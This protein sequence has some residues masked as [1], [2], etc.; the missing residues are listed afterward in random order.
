M[1]IP[2]LLAPDEAETLSPI[3][4]PR[5]SRT[6]SRTPPKRRNKWEDGCGESQNL[7]SDNSAATPS[8]NS[9]APAHSPMTCP[10]IPTMMPG[11]LPSMQPMPSHGVPLNMQHVN[12]N[13]ML[14]LGPDGYRRRIYIGS[15]DYSI[16]ES[17][18][19][20]LFSSFGRVTNVEMPREGTPPR[21]KGFCFLEYSDPESAEKALQNMNEYPLHGRKMRVGRPT[22]QTPGRPMTQPFLLGAMQPLLVPIVMSLDGQP[23][24]MP[25]AASSYKRLFVRNVPKVFTHSHLNELFS[26]FGKVLDGQLIVD[27]KTGTQIA[28]VEMSTIEEANNAKTCMDGKEMIGHALQ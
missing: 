4:Y 1:D 3:F 20:H 15:L 9:S 18:I 27:A 23:I 25:F 10:M 11:L 28:Y 16:D 7:A 22:S 8:T 5:L 24:G 17:E 12:V 14:G 13:N 2:Q 6:R 19:I 21:S 26:V